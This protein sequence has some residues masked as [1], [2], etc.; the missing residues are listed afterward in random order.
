MD[1]HFPYYINGPS[2]GSQQGGGGSHKAV[3]KCKSMVLLSDVSLTYGIV[4]AN[5]PKPLFFCD[6]FKS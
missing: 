1:D 4:W 3:N 5:D 2:A 6:T